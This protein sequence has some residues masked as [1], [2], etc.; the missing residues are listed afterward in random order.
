MAGFWK[1]SSLRP[2]RASTFL[3]YPFRAL[4][5]R[6]LCMGFFFARL[7]YLKHLFQS[8]N[9]TYYSSIIPI[10]LYLTYFTVPDIVSLLCVAPLHRRLYHAHL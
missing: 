5:Q 7:S 8:L 4:L 9:K 1:I 6:P 3:A 2:T 10:V